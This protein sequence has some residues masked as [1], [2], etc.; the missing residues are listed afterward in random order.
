M[1]LDEGD[2]G[3]EACSN[4]SAH[5][6]RRAGT[7]DNQVVAAGRARIRPVRR[8]NV[9][10]EL[11]VERVVGLDQGRSRTDGVSGHEPGHSFF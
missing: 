5:E 11:L 8:V 2:L 6:S 3:T 9:G 10:D 7:D 1:P 4:R